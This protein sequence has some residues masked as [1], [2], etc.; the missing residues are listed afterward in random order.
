[1]LA[2]PNFKKDFIL[3]TDASN[4]GVGAVLMLNDNN[5]KS[6]AIAF[7]SRL[8]NK[9]EQ[10]Y[11]VT[12]REALVVIWAL[13]HFRD[14][15]L[16]YRIHVCTDHSAVTEWFKGKNLSGKPARWQLTVQD[17]NPSFSY[18][19]GKVNTVP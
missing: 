5:G 14:L 16:R 9:P 6:R 1:M 10:N 13:R 12:Y 19:P 11:S 8:L 2:F 7:A 3:C 4:I 18:I 17:Y 15:I